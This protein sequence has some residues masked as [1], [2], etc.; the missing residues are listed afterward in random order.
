MGP[1]G[2]QGN[3][4]VSS[5]TGATGATGYTGFTGSTGVTGP[6]GVGVTGP[7]GPQK[8]IVVH[9]FEQNS[10]TQSFT[11][12]PLSKSLKVTLIGGG[13]GGG[14]NRQPGAHNNTD[15][16]FV[17]TTRP[18]GAGGHAV[19]MIDL[20]QIS[21]SKEFSLV[22][23]GSG[24]GGKAINGWAAENGGLTSISLT[25]GNILL[26]QASG[27]S[28]APQAGSNEI[29]LS[30]PT[31]VAFDGMVGGTGATGPTIQPYVSPI[32]LSYGSDGGDSF[33]TLTFAGTGTSGITG[34]TTWTQL[35]FLNVGDGGHC[36][37]YGHGGKGYCTE[38]I[39]TIGLNGRNA[40]GYGSGGGGGGCYQ[41][42]GVT[43]SSK[44]YDS[45]DGGDGSPGLVIIE[46]Y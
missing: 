16:S 26:A 43:L 13:G 14:A 27:G 3:H 31:I 46:E 29:A 5:N 36:Y 23:G 20:L 22:V 33:G 12:D 35:G 25:N 32:V 1:T 38:G 11:P 9:R 28:A 17:I 41:I 39:T 8:S 40:S 4:G 10:Q 34:T 21:G 30:A 19:V 37:H 6:T 7:T 24:A 44:N 45:V 18:G 2:A 15:E 42:N